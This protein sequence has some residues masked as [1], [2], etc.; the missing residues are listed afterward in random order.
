M[1]LIGKV[2]AVTLVND[3][4]I[5][6][7][8]DFLHMPEAAWD[9]MQA[10][11]V[12]GTCYCTRAVL[13]DMQA[14]GWGRIIN[15]SSVAGLNGGGPGLVH[16]ATAKAALIGLTKALAHEVDP[17][18]IT[19]NA[20]ALGLIDTPLIR[21]AQVPEALLQRLAQDTPM[22]RRRGSHGTSRSRRSCARGSR[23]SRPRRPAPAAPARRE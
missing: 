12:K 11:L 5:C 4:G 2:A 15:V 17:Q 20:I 14:A 16:Y 3:A 21:A 7:Y 22:R 23:P 18:G 19:V 9:R 13:P 6:E 8:T 1:S 10:L